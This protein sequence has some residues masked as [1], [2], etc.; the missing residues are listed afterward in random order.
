ML[1]MH[2]FLILRIH[3]LPGAITKIDIINSFINRSEHKARIFLLVDLQD[4]F[5]PDLASAGY[6]KKRL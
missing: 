1:V 3:I 2:S 4:F 5:S 6:G